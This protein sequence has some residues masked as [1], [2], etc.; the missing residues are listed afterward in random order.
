[1][2]NL[3]HRRFASYPASNGGLRAKSRPYVLEQSLALSWCARRCTRFDSLADVGVTR[4]LGRLVSLP[5]IS[6]ASSPTNSLQQQRFSIRASNSQTSSNTGYQSPPKEIKDI[7]L[8]PPEPLFSFSPDRN[9]ILQLDRPPVLPPIVELAR[10]ELKLAGLRIDPEGYCPSRMSYYPSLSLRHYSE[11]LIMPF[12]TE[13]S[14]PIVGIPEECGVGDVA[15]SPDSSQLAF[16]VRKSGKEVE[17]PPAKLYVADTATGRARCVIDTP[18]NSVL[19][20]FSWIDEKTI[21]ATCL[22]SNHKDSKPPSS[23]SV[24]V[25]PKI[26]DNTDGL[27]S[28]SRTY[29]DLLRNSN[30][31]HQFEH[32][33][34]SQLVLIDVV[35]GDVKPINEPRMYTSV[36]PSPDGRYLLVA[37]LQRP[38]SYSVPAGRFPKKVELWDR[39]GNFL[40]VIAD[41][42]LALDI[43]PA[44]DSCRK[45]PRNITWRDDEPST[46][47]WAEAQDGGDPSVNVSPRDIVFS[48]RID[49][50]DTE[51]EK[52]AQTDMRFVGITWG[53]DKLAL[54]YETER[55]TRTSRCWLFEPGNRLKSSP[56]LV[57]DRN[58]EDSY[59]DPGSP[60]LRR[61]S[62]GRY[63]LAEVGAPL[64]LLLQGPG[65]SPQGNRPFLDL[66]H[67]E[68]GNKK[69]IWE[70]K[71][72]FHEYASSI[73]TYSEDKEKSSD[74]HGSCIISLSGLT[75]LARRET[76]EEPPQYY[77]MTFEEA[78][79]KEVN[80]L[81][82]Q[83]SEF[84]HPYPSLKGLTKT[85]LKYKREDGVDLTA[86]LY[87]PP[88]Y[89]SD[90]D[91]KLP[92][93]LWA[94]PRDFKSRDAAGQLRRSQYA[95]DSIGPNSPLLF[96]TQG[97]AIMDG[98]TFPI[99]GEGD[100]EPNDSYNKQLVAS[101]KAAIVELDRQGVVDI[102]RVA[103]GGHSYGA[104][105]VAGVLAHAPELF[106]CGIAR[107]GAYNR[108]LTPFGFQS[109]E[110]T[111]WQAPQA[112]FDMSPFS[113]C[114]KIKRPVLIIHGEADNNPGTFPMQSE[115]FFAAL[116]AHGVKSRLVVL[117]WESHSYV[118]EESVCHVLAETHSWLQR[119]C[120]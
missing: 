105:M 118:A 14:K 51:P 92:A 63:V 98:P 30:D 81:Y 62:L 72:P 74:A 1:M 60:L 54:L 100:E 44:F 91:G 103:I 18:L 64:Q 80:Y 66:F 86:T 37:W 49:G 65:A 19:Y 68:T 97:F 110:R 38:F 104:F 73:L 2:L 117:P 61:T 119:Y 106:A 112:Y 69:R 116:R 111:L 50:I 34:T 46:I 42:P 108:S 89:K 25:G 83:I 48:L 94:Y 20:S 12:Q 88:G 41:L 9:V 76:V 10:P 84:K 67:L 96:L 87:L 28:Q 120:K 102:S 71:P 43:P 13:D 57:F 113:H 101:A 31:E 15:W 78:Q 45:G 53:H 40:R 3:L 35:E 17:R 55:K 29:Q 23:A 26:E 22:P 77:A 109:E 114:D 16:I 85:I 47:I 24:P 5:W 52:I 75:M 6:S 79:G 11:D 27:K 36:S 56:R 7:V 93:L 33:C 32:Y 58:Y 115:R 8:A 39:E 90:R 4:S 99:I 70:S 82:R 59:S 21:V 95:F 107:S